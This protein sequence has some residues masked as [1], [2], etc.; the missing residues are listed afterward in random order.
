MLQILLYG[1]LSPNLS[2]LFQK[3]CESKKNYTRK[4]SYESNTNF[5]SLQLALE[6]SPQLAL[7]KSPQL[8]FEKSPQLA[9][10][11]SLQLALEKSLQQNI[12]TY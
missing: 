2:R 10:E 3:N 1:I 4:I 11:K 7:E 9:L 5:Q 8:A 6:K 12:T